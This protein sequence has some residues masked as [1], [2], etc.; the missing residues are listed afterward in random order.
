MINRHIGVIDYSIYYRWRDFAITTSFRSKIGKSGIA[1]IATFIRRVRILKRL[2][3]GL[4]QYRWPK[5]VCLCIN[6]KIKR[7]RPYIYLKNA[8]KGNFVAKPASRRQYRA[9]QLYKNISMLFL[10]P[11]KDG[12]LSTLYRRQCNIWCIMLRLVFNNQKQEAFEKCCAHSPLRAAACTPPVLILC[13]HSPGVATVARRHCRTPLRIDVHN[14]NNNND[15]ANRG[16]RYMAPLGPTLQN[17]CIN[18]ISITQPTL[19]FYLWLK[20]RICNFHANCYD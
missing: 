10:F 17:N 12:K 5:H 20:C 4:S 18:N 2:K 3:I 7:R 9:H 11:V 1:S 14:N 16:D 15:N 13:C 19:S 8:L 6:A